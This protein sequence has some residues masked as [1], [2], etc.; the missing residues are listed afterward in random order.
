MGGKREY[1]E[2]NMH[3]QRLLRYEGNIDTGLISTDVLDR[4]LT[5]AHKVVIIS[6]PGILGLPQQVAP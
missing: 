4:L 5:L 2:Q 1:M 6:L 3:R